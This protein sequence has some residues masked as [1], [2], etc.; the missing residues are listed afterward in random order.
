[1]KMQD[2]RPPSQHSPPLR[3]PSRATVSQICRPVRHRRHALVANGL[4]DIWFSYQEQNVLLM[5]P[6]QEQARSAA[7]KINQYIKEIQGSWRGR[8]CCRST[9]TLDEWKMDAR[10]L[11]LVPAV[12][13]VAQLDAGRREQMRL[14]VTKD[15]RQPDRLFAT[16]LFRQS[17]SQQSLLWAGSFCS[18][19]EPYMTIAMAGSAA[20]TA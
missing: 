4:L 8:H 14:A 20:T 5:G 12:T 10:L 17:R 6:Q 1:M 15:G 19:S 16:R 13:A 9:D 18:R 7:A 2:A 3:H 11:R